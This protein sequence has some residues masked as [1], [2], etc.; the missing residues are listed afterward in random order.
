M[1]T[2]KCA[3]IVAGCISLIIFGLFTMDWFFLIFVTPFIILLFTGVLFFYGR[4]IE[5]E[6]IRSVSNVK[7]FENDNVE[8]TLKLK[9]KG[10]TIGFLELYDTLPDKVGI[11]KGS[12]YSALNLKK[13]EEI[14]LKYEISCPL[15]GHYLLGPLRLR[16]RDYLGMFYKETIIENAFDLTVI[17]SIEE[18][19]DIAVKAKANLY[20]GIMQTKQSGT[21]TEFFGLRTYTSGDTFKRINWKSFARWNSLMV[22]EYELESTTDVIILLD[23][24]SIQTIGTIKHNPLEYGIKGATSIASHF[25]KRRDRVGLIVYGKSEGQ[26]R[27]VYP[28]SGKKQLY[29]LIGELVEIQADGHFPLNAAIDTA[30]TYMLPKKSLIIL[31]SSLEGDWSIPGAVERLLAL[32]FN[33][34]VL[35]PSPADIEYSLCKADVNSK[36]AYR[37]LSLDR[38][39]SITKLQNK[40][41]RVV[42]WNP[43]MPLAIS[44]KEVERYQIRR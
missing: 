34:M 16:V 24:R 36:L 35:S 14:S 18:I 6:A 13:D 2:T 4:D 7:V 22:N 42:D 10:A 39:N 31:I 26:L 27:W 21:G 44:L 32:G 20:P 30:V 37:I 9:N 25:L 29:K 1:R 8:V 5:I 40:G 3:S 28:E 15:R 38:K 17:P 41:A 43:T 11:E 23:A 33:I 12:N 19:G